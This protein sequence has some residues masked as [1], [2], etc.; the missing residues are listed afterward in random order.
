METAP[1]PVILWQADPRGGRVVVACC[2][3]ARRLGVRPG[4][5]IAQATELVSH[6]P[7]RGVPLRS[8]GDGRRGR[9]VAAAAERPWVEQHDPLSDSIALQRVAAAL[10]EQ[11]SP[12]VAIETLDRRPWAGQVINQPETI[13]CDLSGV[14]HLFGGESGILAAAHR[15][16]AAFGLKAKLAIA[17]NAAAA[18][19]HAHYNRR[20][21][22]LSQDLVA[23]LEPLSIDALRIATET[24]HT[25]DRLGIETVG[26][27]IRLPRAGLARRLGEPLVKRL[28]EILGEYEVPMHVI[29]Q[30][31]QPQATHVLQY[32]TDDLQ[33]VADRIEGL[34]RQLV[35]QTDGRGVLRLVC[36]FRLVDER[37]WEH[38]VG[39]FAPTLDAAYLGELIHAGLQSRR[40]PSPITAITL[41]VLQSDRMRTTQR[42]LFAEDPVGLESDGASPRSLSRLV[43]AL[44]VRMGREAVLGVRLNRNPLPEKAYRTYSL[45]DHSVRRAL[46]Q[47]SSPA[48]KKK[49]NEDR[50]SD[51]PFTAT[52]RRH[53]ERFVA[54]SSQDARRRPVKLLRNPIPLAVVPSGLPDPG[55]ARS[56]GNANRLPAFRVHGQVHR[57]AYFWGP[58]RIETGWWE[59]PSVRRDYYRIETDRGQLW[60]VF[61]DLQGPNAW[62]LHG[63]FF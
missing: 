2:P 31:P 42:S 34:T 3:R 62:F 49:T 27:L 25:L 5:A 63:R 8:G 14:A 15:C 24:R 32:P 23:D 36:R 29:R 22:F 43:D 16:L 20:D 59:G 61:R 40:L 9:S 12:L 6:G 1:R 53:H 45:T 44:T 52:G 11:L 56:G 26:A 17:D 39:L 57:V 60:W 18:W 28:A 50:T 21:D 19:A 4:I 58:E 35:A 51:H 10:Q 13:L 48:E 37:S 47:L 38:R 41:E 54:P 55:P 30:A 46:R 7:L 33:I